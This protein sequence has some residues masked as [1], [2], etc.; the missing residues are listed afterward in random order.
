ME[1][2]VNQSITGNQAKIQFATLAFAVFDGFYAAP[3]HPRFAPISVAIGLSR[4]AQ[5]RSRINSSKFHDLVK[6][7]G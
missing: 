1:M 7:P 6:Y 5:I 4:D 3:L 2:R